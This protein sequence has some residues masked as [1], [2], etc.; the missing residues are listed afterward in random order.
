MEIINCLKPDNENVNLK[1]INKDGKDNE[2]LNLNKN[3]QNKKHDN[4]IPE[5]Y[6][7]KFI[8]NL[9]MEKHL[10]GTAFFYFD[11]KTDF[12]SLCSDGQLNVRGRDDRLFKFWGNSEFRTIKPNA[13]FQNLKAK[14]IKV[15][16]NS[17]SG[18]RVLLFNSY[19]TFIE[20]LEDY[21]EISKS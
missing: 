6:D 3:P 5:K 15:N 20:W 16:F 21:S 4:F 18:G 9:L 13:I 14:V 10:R 19:A 11:D 2:T 7:P 12:I 17:F 8:V 1:L